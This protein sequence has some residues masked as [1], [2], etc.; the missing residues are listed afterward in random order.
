MFAAVKP[1][2]RTLAGGSNSKR[3]DVVVRLNAH[4]RC[5][6]HAKAGH[7]HPC[8]PY[9]TRAWT[10]RLCSRGPC[11]PTV[12]AGDVLRGPVGSTGVRKAIEKFKPVLGVRGHIHE[13]A[14]ERRIGETLCVN[15]GSEANHGLLRGY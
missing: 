13:S 11:G 12:S 4:V 5:A 8:P 15:A 3:G 6:R 1:W 7:D 2:S 9:S 10:P 14:G